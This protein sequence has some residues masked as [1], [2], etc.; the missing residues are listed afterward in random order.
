MA[1]GG[2]KTGSPSSAEQRRKYVLGYEDRVPR[3]L[4][5]LYRRLKIMSSPYLPPN[6]AQITSILENRLPVGLPGIGFEHSDGKS[7]I[8]VNHRSEGEWTASRR[9]GHRYSVRHPA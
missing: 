1:A 8:E 2:S 5:V 3:R 4:P 9:R 7:Y 6:V